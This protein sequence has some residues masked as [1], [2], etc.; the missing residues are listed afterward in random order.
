MIN[1]VTDVLTEN[2]IE[3]DRIHFELFTSSTQSDEIEENLDGETKVTVLVD[4]ES[5]S[6]VMNQKTTILD[7]ALKEDIDAPYSCQGGVCS[8]CICR[9]TQGTAVMEKNS[10]LT[11]SELAEGLVL[12][13]QAHPTSSSIK[14]DF[15]DV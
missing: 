12:A 7:A 13:C 10:I 5:F 14:V 8:S 1:L 3:K 9:I 2:S 6:F 15:D 4:D 11:D